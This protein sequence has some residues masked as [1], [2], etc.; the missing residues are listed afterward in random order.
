MPTVIIPAARL[1][2]LNPFQMHRLAE[3]MALRGVSA[4]KERRQ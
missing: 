3:A 4:I 2:R 1:A